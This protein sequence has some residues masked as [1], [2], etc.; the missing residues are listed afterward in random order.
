VPP[1][2]RANEP[3]FT[4]T[5]GEIQQA[6]E[7]RKKELAKLKQLQ[8]VLSGLT[9]IADGK[10]KAFVEANKPNPKMVAEEAVGRYTVAVQVG[11]IQQLWEVEEDS[12]T[13]NRGYRPKLAANNLMPHAINWFY[14]PTKLLGIVPAGKDALEQHALFKDA[15]PSTAAQIYDILDDVPLAGTAKA[16]DQVIENWDTNPSAANAAMLKAGI[17]F[18]GDVMMFAPAVGKVANYAASKIESKLVTEVS[19]RASTELASRTG[20]E[21]VVD[22]KGTYKLLNSKGEQVVAANGQKIEGTSAEGLSKVIQEANLPKNALA[23]GKLTPKGNATIVERP[24]WDSFSAASRKADAAA[25][26]E[27]IKALES[28]GKQG[29]PIT[30]AMTDQ[31]RKLLFDEMAAITRATGKE[32]ALVQRTDGTVAM[33]IGEADRVAIGNNVRSIIGHTHPSGQLG[34]SQDL[35]EI[36][37]VFREVGDVQRLRHLNQESTWVIAPDGTAVKFNR[38][39][40]DWLR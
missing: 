9:E 31:G 25:N 33:V 36:N 7:T 14:K 29:I 24:S 8:T 10:A 26:A 11:N 23:N 4:L 39:E 15:S 3:K 12:L 34:L 27:R 19:S 1:A 28:V 5:P 35:R 6:V 2:A 17:S 32:V 38:S 21:V 30:S 18:A 37:G 16:V 13:F 20:Y 40:W 22:S